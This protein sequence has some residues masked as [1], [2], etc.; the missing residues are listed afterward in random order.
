MASILAEII[1]VFQGDKKPP[2]HC[3]LIA[4]VEVLP[5]RL[6]FS[7]IDQNDDLWPLLS[8]KNVQNC[9]GGRGKGGKRRREVNL[10]QLCSVYCIPS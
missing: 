9:E 7:L 4:L 10:E 3:R 1:F 2:L 5:R 8:E 6:H